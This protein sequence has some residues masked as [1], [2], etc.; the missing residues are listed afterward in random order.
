MDKLPSKMAHIDGLIAAQTQESLHLD[1][2]DSRAIDKNKRLEISKDV[3]AF[4][5]SAGGVIIYGV[6]E[7]GHLPLA[8]DAGVDDTQYSREWLEQVI[9]SN[10]SPR[11]H[12]VRVV[13]ISVSQGRSLYVVGVPESYRGPHQAADKKYYKRF[14]F[15]SVAMEDYEIRDVRNRQ[16]TVLPLMD[17]DVEI[18]HGVMTLLVVQ[19]I[20]GFPARDVAFSFPNGIDW[21][22]GRELPTLLKRGAKTVPPGKK[23]HFFY[24]SYIDM[25][26]AGMSSALD[27]EVSY[28]HPEV[29][30]RITEVFHIDFMDY[31]QAA[32]VESELYE[33]G[34][35]IKKALEQLRECMKP[36]SDSLKA[37]SAIASP[38]GLDLSLRT[39][40]NLAHV[41]ARDGEFE[42]LNPYG[43]GWQVF[44]DVLGIDMQLA[45]KLHQFFGRCDEG[46]RLSDVEGMT[47]GILAELQQRFEIREE[48]P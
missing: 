23:Y 9:N 38:T 15:Q 48:G 6:R 21:P 29:T 18:K 19:N 4:A 14:N 46:K 24:D 32:V 13:P 31:E 35:T 39:V 36:S 41:L 45:W 28:F 40:T 27:I 16:H 2:K 10:I 3:S 30:E 34:R 33:L 44:R 12:G 1:Y 8:K 7:K 43:C 47:Q 11:I 37:L 17:V 26:K 5:N 42:K 20:G 25:V 22:R